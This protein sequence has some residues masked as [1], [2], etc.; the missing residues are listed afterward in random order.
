MTE[1]YCVE[2]NGDYWQSVFPS[3]ESDKSQLHHSIDDAVYYMRRECD[4]NQPITIFGG[5][6]QEEENVKVD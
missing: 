5:F 2:W 1:V 4:V 6:E 3:K